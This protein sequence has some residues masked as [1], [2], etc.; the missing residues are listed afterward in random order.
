M[1]E[2]V[3]RRPGPAWELLHFLRTSR[4]YAALIFFLALVIGACLHMLNHLLAAYLLVIFPLW[5][6][7][8]TV[9]LKRGK[10]PRSLRRQYCWM[11]AHSLALL[12][13]LLA[14]SSHAGY[15]L[16][17]LGFDMPLSSAGAWGL[18]CAVLLICGLWAIGSMIERRKTP[19]ART[20][21]ERKMPASSF[22]WPRN[23][24]EAFA[25][26]TSMLVVTS[27]WEVLYRGFLLLVLTP[28]IGLALAIAASA[29]AYGIGHGYVNSKQLAG[30]IISA[31]FF[32]IA[33]A[34]TQSLWGLIL[35]HV[36]ISLSTIPA[37]LRA[38]R[39]RCALLGHFASTPHQK[40]TTANS[41]RYES[42]TGMSSPYQG[43]I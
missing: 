37:V 36:F 8:R 5:N 23:L 39:H 14:G 12:G 30:S 33:Y 24:A 15:T 26:A 19:Q 16:E 20:E 28:V 1:P 21:D 25:F 6:L 17:Q 9:R 13:V 27:G 40:S 10:P 41:S 22:I 7:W 18:V 34:W 3:D 35:I 11:S 2:M 42:D 29:L 4:C 43:C 32:T 38:Q 31:F